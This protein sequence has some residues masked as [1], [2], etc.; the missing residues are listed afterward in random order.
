MNYFTFAET[1]L[2]HAWLQFG[3]LA[4]NLQK[5]SN[6]FPPTSLVCDTV[7]LKFSRHKENIFSV[8]FFFV[9]SLFRPSHQL[10]SGNRVFRCGGCRHSLEAFRNHS[11]FV[12][13][14]KTNF[15]AECILIS[16]TPGERLLSFALLQHSHG[17]SS[18]RRSRRSSSSSKIAECIGC[19]T[20]VC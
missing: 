10:C 5:Q 20:C 9:P 16:Y 14:E 18:T 17:H 13:N 12:K 8:F 2:Q 19:Q 4:T 11:K 15:S 1:N 3:L 6:V 7:S